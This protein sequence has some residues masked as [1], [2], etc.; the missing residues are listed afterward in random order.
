M[1]E[2]TKNNNKK[3]GNKMLVKINNKGYEFVSLKNTNN[4]PRTEAT[5]NIIKID[6]KPSKKPN[7]DKSLASPN[8]I[9]SLFLTYL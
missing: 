7:A 6:F 9:A 1:L 4:N 5:N 2:Q 3:R 8:P